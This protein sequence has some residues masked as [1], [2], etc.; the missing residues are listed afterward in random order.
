MTMTK[1]ARISPVTIERRQATAAI[2]EVLDAATDAGIPYTVSV[3]DAGGHLISVIRE[4]GA[5]LASIDTS[6]SKART[7]LFF[8]Q[9]TADL[10]AAIQPGAP[11]YSI[12]T[13]THWPLAFVAGGVPVTDGQG[14]VVG[15]VGAGGASPQED[16]DIATAVAGIIQKTVAR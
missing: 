4:D 15:A 16:H 9:S 10:Q 12:E 1:L 2:E 3:I 8:A 5:A 13:S 7:A 11:L 14:T 6:Q